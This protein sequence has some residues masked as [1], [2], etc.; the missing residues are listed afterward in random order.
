MTYD[1]WRTRD[2]EPL[3]DPP[4]VC[5]DCGHPEGY[6]DHSCCNESV[7]LD[8]DELCA[9]A[10]A[11]WIHDDGIGPCADCNCQRFEVKP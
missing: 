9:C 8:D 5:E 6:C 4:E 2:E 1:D 3:Y 10:C 7:A 11:R